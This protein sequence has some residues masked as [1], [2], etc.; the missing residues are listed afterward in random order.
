MQGGASG[1]KLRLYVRIGCDRD[2][3]IQRHHSG[4]T[5]IAVM[6]AYWLRG[7]KLEQ[8]LS[9]GIWFDTCDAADK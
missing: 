4:K 7:T 5:S 9:L 8:D 6:V 3:Q 1:I 2:A